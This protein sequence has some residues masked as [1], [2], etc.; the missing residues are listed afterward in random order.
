MK[1]YRLLTI[2]LALLVVWLGYLQ[3][4]RSGKPASEPVKEIWQTNTVERWHTNTVERW[5]TNTVNVEVLRT[6]T[7]LQ[8]VTNEVI[9]EVPAKLSALERR[10]ATAGYKFVNAPLLAKRS[11]PLYKAS[12]LAVDV[13]IQESATGILSEGTDAVKKRIVSALSSRSIPV[14]E[15]SPYRLSLGI[16]ALWRTDAPS[17]ALLMFKMELKEN[18]ALQRQG[19]IFQSAGIVWSTATSRL[20]RRVD[21]GE[22]VNNLMQDQL[23]QFCNDYLSAKEAEKDIESR[24]PPIPKDFLSEQ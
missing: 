7:V 15:K 9:K 21:T 12:P 1:A 5:H 23:K 16:S 10:A 6:D 11:D 18:V 22:E 20:I 14:A 3:L 2:V 8:T 4:F 24:I 17:V 19:D 13:H